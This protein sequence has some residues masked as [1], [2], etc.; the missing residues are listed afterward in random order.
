MQSLRS[1]AAKRQQTQKDIILPNVFYL[2]IHKCYNNDNEIQTFLI[3]VIKPNVT[4]SLTQHKKKYSNDQ[5]Y[6][7]N[8]TDTPY[9]WLSIIQHKNVGFI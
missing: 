6:D 1:V 2:H 9:L 5:P 8:T 4:L 7:H 3:Q